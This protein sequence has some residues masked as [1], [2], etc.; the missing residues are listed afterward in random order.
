MT[1]K[2]EIS[3]AFRD[4]PGDYL[5]VLTTD[6]KQLDFMLVERSNAEAGMLQK[7]VVG[8]QPPIHRVGGAYPRF[9][10][11]NRSNPGDVALRVLRLFSYTRGQSVFD[12]SERLRNAYDVAYWSEEYFNNRAL[13]SGYYLKERLPEEREEWRKPDNKLLPEDLDD[14]DEKERD[15]RLKPYFD[16]T[17]TF[18][19]RLLFLL[20]AESRNLLPVRETDTYYQRSLEKLK[21]DIKEKAGVSE[22]DAPGKIRSAYKDTTSTALYDGLQVVFRAVDKGDKD[23]NVPIYNGGLFMT[24]PHELDT[25]AE[26]EA[27]RFLLAHKMGATTTLIRPSYSTSNA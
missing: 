26:A 1:A 21:Q 24:E 12:Y 17:L 14:L 9:L 3:R 23:L 5:L 13:F 7:E 20:Y 10:T 11:V 27:A 6:Y 4:R 25:S 2:K 18:L 15:S 22:A 8:M 16:G 19:Y